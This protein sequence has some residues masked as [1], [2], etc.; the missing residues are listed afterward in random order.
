[1]L[2]TSFI[3]FVVA[4][5]GVFPW[6]GLLTSPLAEEVFFRRHT[7][8]PYDLI[9]FGLMFVTYLWAGKKLRTFLTIFTIATL[10]AFAVSAIL[11][12]LAGEDCSHYCI[13]MVNK[14]FGLAC[15]YVGDGCEL[16]NFLVFFTLFLFALI[17]GNTIWHRIYT[18]RTTSPHR[19]E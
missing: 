18:Q 2:R 15:G 11:R 5:V 7:A 17:L 4:D 19:L 9:P 8:A 14:Y 3:G 6:I 13:G 12:H 1:M 16:E 10:G